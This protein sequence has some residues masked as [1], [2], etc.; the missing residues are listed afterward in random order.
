MLEGV[1]RRVWLSKGL[2]VAVGLAYAAVGPPLVG[3]DPAFVGSAFV[4]YG[5]VSFV[6]GRLVDRW[7]LSRR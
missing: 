3:L 7:G 2:F 5:V 6:G 4:A 1:P